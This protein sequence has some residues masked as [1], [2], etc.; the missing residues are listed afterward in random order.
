MNLAFRFP[1]IFWNCACLIT[2]AGG[3]E[4]ENEEEIEYE[5]VEEVY[6]NEIEEFG[7]DDNDDEEDNDDDEEVTTVKKKKK[8]KTS[9]Y[10][11][12]L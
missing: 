6:Y 2:D 12:I 9:N 10:G 1:I 4:S 5:E 8:T 7:P 11:R 3:G